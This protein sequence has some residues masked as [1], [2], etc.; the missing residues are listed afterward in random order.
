MRA[1]HNMR[2]RKTKRIFDEKKIMKKKDD[3]EYV[4]FVYSC[5]SAG[6]ALKG[7]L[8]PP[9][10]EK[11]HNKYHTIP[12]REESKVLRKPPANTD[13]IFTIPNLIRHFLSVLG[14]RAEYS[15][16]VLESVMRHRKIFLKEKASCRTNS[17]RPAWEEWT[18]QC[19]AV[20]GGRGG[21]VQ[22]FRAI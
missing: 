4:N 7:L 11:L 22:C 12:Q 20:Q 13:M 10:K 15:L 6:T 18:P 17:E 2:S 21:P 1:P 19:R 16:C 9:I 8:C 3:C 5:L 14:G